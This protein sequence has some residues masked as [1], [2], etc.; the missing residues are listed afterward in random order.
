MRGLFK[1]S[2][3]ILIAV[4]L[5]SGQ[6]YAASPAQEAYFRGVDFAIQGNFK[7]AKVAF[8]EALRLYPSFSSAK[9]SLE[10]VNDAL[11]GKFKPKAA[12]YMFRAVVHYNK[13][14][15]GRAIVEFTHAIKIDP[16]YPGA[17]VNLGMAYYRNKQYNRAIREFNRALKINP[18]S[19]PAYNNRGLALSDLGQHGRA[20]EDFSRVIKLDPRN[21]SGYNNRGYEYLVIQNNKIKGC[22]DWKKA[23]ELG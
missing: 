10:I 23:C 4:F 11:T 19:V 18:N 6:A 17:Y 2:L 9:N 5:L 7:K 20:I 12:I 8:E 21:D 3:P 15:Y 13:K 16:G 14:D 22:R 1:T